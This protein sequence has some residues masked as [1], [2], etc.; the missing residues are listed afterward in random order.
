M[1]L[2]IKKIFYYADNWMV[3]NTPLTLELP[4]H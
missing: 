4:A 1:L 3:K 2:I